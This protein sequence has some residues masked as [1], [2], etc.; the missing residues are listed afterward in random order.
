MAQ[1]KSTL[2]VPVRIKLCIVVVLKTMLFGTLEVTRGF[3]VD[4]NSVW[5]THRPFQS[6]SSQLLQKL[7][8]AD[9][10]QTD[11]Y[12]AQPEPAAEAAYR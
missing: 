9:D 6:V 8:Y 2:S 1:L 4:S 5:L 10:E 12:F 3:A 11:I 7:L